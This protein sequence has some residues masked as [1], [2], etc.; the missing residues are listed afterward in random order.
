MLQETVH[1]NGQVGTLVNL[2]KLTGLIFYVC[3]LVPLKI[4][5]FKIYSNRLRF[6]FKK[7]KAISSKFCFKFT[8][9]T[10]ENEPIPY[11]II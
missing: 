2:V 8:R 11:S 10:L 1:K 6:I 3:F 5:H 7:V 9:D 4:D